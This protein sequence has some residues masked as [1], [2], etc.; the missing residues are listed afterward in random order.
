MKQ[1]TSTSVITVIASH[2]VNWVTL[3]FKT[4]RSWVPNT[5]GAA[6]GSTWSPTIEGSALMCSAKTSSV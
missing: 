2:F 1:Y 6:S 4:C 3:N 5:P